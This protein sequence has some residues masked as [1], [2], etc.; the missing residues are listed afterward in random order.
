MQFEKAKRYLVALLVTRK[1]Q[2]QGMQVATNPMVAW[3]LQ[4]K[5]PQ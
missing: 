5:G 1:W 3:R 4:H 2:D